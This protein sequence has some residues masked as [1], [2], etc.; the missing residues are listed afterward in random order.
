MKEASKI[1]LASFFMRK[2]DKNTLL[3]QTI[4]LTTKGELANVEMA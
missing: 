1:L 4:L 3:L 2:M